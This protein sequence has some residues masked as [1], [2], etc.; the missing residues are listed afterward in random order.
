[1]AFTAKQKIKTF[2]ALASVI[3]LVRCAN[4]LPPG[5]GEIDTTPPEIIYSYPAN[6]TVNYSENYF[7]LE[8]SEYVDKRSFKEALFVSPAFDE[9]FEISW[10][11]KSVEVYFPDGLKDNVTY[12]VTIGTDVVDVNNRNRMA[13]SYSFAFSTGEKIDTRTISGKVYGKGI[14]GTLIFAYRFIDD[15]TTYLSRKPDY[16]SQIG[17]DGSY[18]LNGLSEAVYRVFAVKDQLRDFIYQMDQDEIGIP[19]KDINLTG[20]D[21]SFS[22]LNFFINKIDTVAPRLISTVMT[23]RNHILVTLSE[24]CD[25]SVF[26]AS[27]FFI[28]DS[29]SNQIL[30]PVFAFSSIA[31]KDEIVLVQNNALKDDHKYYL[32]VR[33]LTDLSGNIFNDDYKELIIS[34]RADTSAPKLINK[35]PEQQSKIDF[36]NTVFTFYFDDAIANK[37]IQKALSFTDTLKNK[38]PFTY[39]FDDDATLV[40]KPSAD[41]KPDRSFIITINLSFFADANGNKTDSVYTHKFSTISGIEFTGISGRINSERKNIILLLQDGKNPEKFY[42]TKPDQTNTF[43]FVRIDAGTY[44]L[45]YYFDDDSSNTYNYGYPQPFKFAEEFNFI[46]DTVKLRARWSVTDFNINAK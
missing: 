2:F 44:K 14:E 1:M 30:N 31:K 3:F 33:K 42:T 39:Y 22:G 10:S 16:L 23:D 46:P 32:T 15:T 40:I 17:K 6:G 25:T 37:E 27:N 9:K 41:L 26:N 7:E 4:Q 20:S 29:T 19:F 18:K 11:G 45:W 12:V 38:I 36:L 8:F 13:N 34:D 5:G 43:K 28:Y 21:S 24:Q 35:Q